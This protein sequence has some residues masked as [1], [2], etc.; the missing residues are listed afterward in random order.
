[1]DE[2][3]VEDMELGE[4]DLDAIEKEYE[5][6]S[7]EQVELLQKA[8]I[9]S[10]AS[11]DLGINVDPTKGSKRKSPEEDLKRGHKT[12]KQRIAAIGVK[13][14]ESGQYPTIRKAFFEVSK[15]TQ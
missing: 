9:R 12:N 14:I 8:I 11:Q 1:M 7:R 10:K 6:V 5:Y 2:D 13:L 3:D 15:V 4:L